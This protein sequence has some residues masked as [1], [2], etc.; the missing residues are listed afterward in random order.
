MSTVTI[1]QQDFAVQE[2]FIK[3]LYNSY[4]EQSRRRG[5]PF[6]YSIRTYGCQLNE[7]DSE[8]ISGYLKKISFSP[9]VTDDADLVIFNTCS[10]REHAQDRLFGNLGLIKAAKR[11]NPSMIVAV[12]GCMMK[13]TDN[14]EKIKKSFPFVDLVFGPQD[15][16]RIPEFLHRLHFSERKIYD[17]SEIDY[18]ADD[19]D[20][21]I[22]RSRK[23]RALVPIMYGCN[24]FCT[25]C[26]VPYT[27]GR[28]RS[29]S[30]KSI[31]LEIQTL[32]DEGYK[33][34][35]LLGQNVNSYGLDRTDDMSFLELLTAI[36]K[37]PGMYRIRF[38][39]SHPRDMSFEVIDVMAAHPNIERHLHLPVQSGSDDVLKRMNRKY[40]REE[41]LS[42]VKYY[43]EKIPDGTLSTD[44]IVGFPG[45][46]EE[47]FK[48]TLSLTS[49][50]AFD[51]AFTFQYSIRPGTPAASMPD[52]VPSEIVSERFQRLLDLQNDNCYQS[53][54]SVVDKVEEV[55]I[56]G[57]SDTSEN[58]FS[59]RTSSNRLVNFSIPDGKILPW[60]DVFSSD[61][62]IDGSR[63]EGKTALVR[64]TRARPY[65]LAGELE[66]FL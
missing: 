53:N 55:L 62:T 61:K 38:M 40:T 46:T 33:E 44:I 65:S 25:F 54:L 42:L 30:S 49:E 12:C 14:V 20:M 6:T 50:A 32:I 29:R 24:K 1:Q 37:L 64:L 43:R 58:I 13:Q 60:G 35:M 23:F 39:T 18:I 11:K 59:A 26:I 10:V 16:H 57:R 66:H 4:C 3:E 47:D 31:L 48:Q 15:I 7:S 36:A 41:F 9:A 52:Q 8:K 45:E 28:E 21:P 56:E 2:K 34:I 51:S 17:V 5:Y 27:R 22:D 63:L 19:L